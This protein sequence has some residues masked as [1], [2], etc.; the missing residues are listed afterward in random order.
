[1]ATKV[2][3]TAQIL[4]LLKTKK[5]VTNRE[6]NRICYRYGARIWELRREGHVIVTNRVKDSLFE[7]VYRGHVE[8]GVKEYAD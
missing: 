3:Q 1:M 5:R 7:F 2:S 8:D 6:L 4:N